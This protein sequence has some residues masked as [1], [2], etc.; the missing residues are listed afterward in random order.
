MNWGTCT[1]CIWA[2][3]VF[4]TT[5]TSKCAP[6]STCLGLSVS[7]NIPLSTSWKQRRQWRIGLALS[8]A[9]GCLN[10]RWLDSMALP[11]ADSCSNSKFRT[12]NSRKSTLDNMCEHWRISNGPPWCSFQ[13]VPGST[14]RSPSSNQTVRPLINLPA[15]RRRRAKKRRR[16]KKHNWLRWVKSGAAKKVPPGFHPLA[17]LSRIEGQESERS[18][19]VPWLGCRNVVGVQVSTCVRANA[20]HEIRHLQTAGEYVVQNLVDLSQIHNLLPI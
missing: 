6:I 9:P 1:I 15:R 11:S 10:N 17:K 7:P 12:Y 20:G 13:M 5:K 19:G 4:F 14:A 3:G 2:F 8:L 18:V 16:G